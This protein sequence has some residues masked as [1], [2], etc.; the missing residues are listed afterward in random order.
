MNRNDNLSSA[1]YAELVHAARKLVAAVERAI[2]RSEVVFAVAMGL[3]IAAS[4]LGLDLVATITSVIAVGA[5]GGGLILLMARLALG[6]APAEVAI[7]T[8][9][10]ELVEHPANGSAG[11]ATGSGP[12]TATNRRILR[13]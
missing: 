4:L 9:P 5:L 13:K 8:T 2:H 12:A 6:P 7:T 10:T 1:E 11:P 3:T